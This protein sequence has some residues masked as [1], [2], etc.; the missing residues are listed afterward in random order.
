MFGEA[1]FRIRQLIRMGGNLLVQGALL[2]R[3]IE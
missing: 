3:R 2:N 1:V